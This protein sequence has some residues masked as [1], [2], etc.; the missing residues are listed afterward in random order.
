MRERVYEI[1]KEAGNKK[2][3]YR[4]SLPFPFLVELNAPIS[5]H[6]LYA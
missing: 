1:I 6:H 5:S 4:Y 2:F 3:L